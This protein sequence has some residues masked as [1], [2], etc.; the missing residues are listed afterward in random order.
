VPSWVSEVGSG[1]FLKLASRRCVWVCGSGPDH[2][3]GGF[4]NERP[5]LLSCSRRQQIGHVYEGLLDHTAVRTFDAALGLV[6]GLEAEISL[7]RLERA[8]AVGD[9]QR[10]ALLTR[11]R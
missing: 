3:P 9:D 4:G 2:V 7:T 11:S 5:A 6:G 1:Q 10:V 8:R